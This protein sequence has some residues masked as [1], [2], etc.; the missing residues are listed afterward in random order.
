M[1]DD[2]TVAERNVVVQLLDRKRAAMPAELYAAIREGV[3]PTDIDRAVLRLTELGVISRA[4][5][6]ALRTSAAIDHLDAL[7]L[8]CV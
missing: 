1:P 4:V 8:I 7:G 2:P 5:N 3:T 6:G